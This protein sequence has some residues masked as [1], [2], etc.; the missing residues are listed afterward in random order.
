MLYFKVFIF[1]GHFV[2]KMNSKRHLFSSKV[3][4]AHLYRF[5]TFECSTRQNPFIWQKFLQRKILLDQAISWICSKSFINNVTPFRKT[6]KNVYD[7][8]D[9]QPLLQCFPPS[10][11]QTCSKVW[12]KD[13]FCGF[14]S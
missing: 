11:T 4:K 10:C 13:I 8:D 7:W 1:H 6:C 12:I 9:T 5:A 3:S 14:L 2:F